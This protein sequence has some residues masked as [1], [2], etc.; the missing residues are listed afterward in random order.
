[1]S[2]SSNLVSITGEVILKNM[3][4]SNIFISSNV[5]INYNNNLINKNNSIFNV[6]LKTYSVLSYG[7]A[8]V[9][10]LDNS[11]LFTYTNTISTI[12]F[13][14]ITVCSVLAVGSGGAGGMF[15]GSGGGGGQVVESI[16][17]FMP[18]IIYNIVVPGNT[19]APPDVNTFA[20][21]NP[22]YITVDN[23]TIIIG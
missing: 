9:S 10:K 1:M 18:N 21:G 8:T 19:T 14:K 7:T 23:N 3:N 13:N 16:I 11:I 5:L 6:Y 20:S 22:S 15:Y 2:I 12:I 17:T 4:I